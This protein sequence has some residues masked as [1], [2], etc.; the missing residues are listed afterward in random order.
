M[1]VAE[2]LNKVLVKWKQIWMIWWIRGWQYF[3]Y[4]FF[5]FTWIKLRQRQNKK[6]KYINSRA[7]TEENDLILR[8]ITN[9]K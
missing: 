2:E 7:Y 5:I 3:I 8:L 9:I 6:I 1:A 4:L